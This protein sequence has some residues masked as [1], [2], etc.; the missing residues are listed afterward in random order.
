MPKTAYDFL[1]ERH[2]RLAHALTCNTDVAKFVQ[3]VLDHLIDRCEARAQDP[4]D[5]QVDRPQILHIGT[6]HVISARIR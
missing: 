4:M 3:G 1:A 2:D 6:K 5:L